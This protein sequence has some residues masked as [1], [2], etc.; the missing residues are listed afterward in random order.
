MWLTIHAI[1][2]FL[3]KLITSNSKYGYAGNMFFYVIR[4]YLPLA[5]QNDNS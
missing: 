4:Y 3:S 2:F 5:I 1:I